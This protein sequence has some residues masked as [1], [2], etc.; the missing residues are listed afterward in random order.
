ML[1]AFSN[2]L[3]LLPGIINH[4]KKMSQHRKVISKETQKQQEIMQ[5]FSFQIG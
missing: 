5:T 4:K 1:K 2:L 3:S